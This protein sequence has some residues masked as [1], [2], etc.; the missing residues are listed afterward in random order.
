VERCRSDS[1]PCV[2]LVQG[3]LFTILAS[4]EWL[5][6]D[7]QEGDR[8]SPA[9]T[10]R[11]A[12]RRTQAAQAGGSGAPGLLV[13][14]SEYST[15]LTLHDPLTGEWH[16]LLA[17]DC[18]PSLV[19]EAER[20]RRKRVTLTKETKKTKKVEAEGDTSAAGTLPFP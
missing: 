3:G 15:W 17:S 1:S 4:V 5:P 9:Q 14:W 11:R 2:V 19:E 16:D 13:R 12:T 6:E 10:L 8:G 20:R 7:G 18:F